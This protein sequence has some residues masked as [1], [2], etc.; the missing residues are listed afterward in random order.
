MWRVECK[1]DFLRGVGDPK[2]KKSPGLPLWEP[3][4]GLDVTQ[5]VILITKLVTN[6]FKVDH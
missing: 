5:S 3:F 4:R 1:S 2:K 6:Y